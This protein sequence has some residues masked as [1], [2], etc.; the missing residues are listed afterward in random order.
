M[1]LL[2]PLYGM[3]RIAGSTRMGQQPVENYCAI[4]KMLVCEGVQ[5]PSATTCGCSNRLSSDARTTLADCF[6]SLL[7]VSFGEERQTGRVTMEKTSPTDRTDF[8]LR[9]KSG[10][11]NGAQP[12]R[13]GSGIMV[14]LPKESLASS[15]TTED[16]RAE[17]RMAMTR[18]IRRKQ[19]VELLAG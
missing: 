15:T 18:M 11:R 10:Q 14:G 7:S 9:E 8:A 5:L 19:C 16:E 6:N 12:R 4:T 1:N 3:V 13:C 2:F 17:R